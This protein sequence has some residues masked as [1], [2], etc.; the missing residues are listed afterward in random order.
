M[1][2]EELVKQHLVFN[3]HKDFDYNSFFQVVKEYQTRLGRPL[4]IVELGTRRWGAVPTHHQQDFQTRGI[5]TSDYVMTDYIE[6]QDVDI[7]VD[8]HK[9]TTSFP[10]ET[11]DVIFSASTF[12]HVKYPWVASHEMMKSLR[13]GGIVFI[14]T[15]QTFPLHGYPY[16]FYRFSR[17]ALESLFPPEMGMKLHDSWYEFLNYIEGQPKHIETYSNVCL[18]VEKAAPT[19]PTFIYHFQ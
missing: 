1:S 4:R 3:E 12:E 18:V 11:V 19:P 14:Q 17:Q 9:F 2:R 16:D 6:G 5:N 13:V 15:H 10:P 7:V 8:L